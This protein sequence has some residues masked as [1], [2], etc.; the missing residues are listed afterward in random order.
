VCS[1]SASL[2]L[3]LKCEKTPRDISSQHRMRTR[4][5]EPVLMKRRGTNRL[6]SKNRK[7]VLFNNFKHTKTTKI[8]STKQG[9]RLSG[10]QLLLKV[11]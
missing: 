7:V 5:D 8:L 6:N 1:L 10:S 11:K 2:Q 3:C 4:S 9:V